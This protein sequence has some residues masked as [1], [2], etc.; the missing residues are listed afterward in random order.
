MA[1]VEADKNHIKKL[2]QYFGKNGLVDIVHA[3]TCLQENSILI[4]NDKHFDILSKNKVI[5]V[6]S[7]NKAIDTLLSED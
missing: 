2:S 3:A 7:I 5:E 6:W 4:T 1:G